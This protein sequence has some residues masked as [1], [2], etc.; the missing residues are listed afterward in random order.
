MVTIAALNTCTILR[1]NDSLTVVNSAEHDP[2]KIGKG[3]NPLISTKEEKYPRGKK[4][5][6]YYI[7]AWSYAKFLFSRDLVVN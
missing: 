4:Y 5:K 3:R 6:S 1:N 2:T 7:L